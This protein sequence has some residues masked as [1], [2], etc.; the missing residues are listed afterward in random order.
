MFGIESGTSIDNKDSLAQ[1]LERIEHAD[2]SGLDVFGIGEH[3]RKR[4]WIQRL[5]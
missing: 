2:Q 1:L 4:F 5:R 3:H